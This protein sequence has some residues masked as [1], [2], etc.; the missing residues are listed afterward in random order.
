MALSR[1]ASACA[2][3]KGSRFDADLGVAL[4]FTAHPTCV[5][6]FLN[7][8]SEL[9][10]G[11][12]N[13]SNNARRCFNRTFPSEATICRAPSTARVIILSSVQQLYPARPLSCPKQERGQIKTPRESLEGFCCSNGQIR[14]ERYIPLG[15]RFRCLSSEVFFAGFQTK[16]CFLLPLCSQIRWCRHAV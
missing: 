11:I 14:W 15:L 16:R 2:S 7:G 9:P 10:F 5:A 6:K 13:A 3:R 1:L 4:C 8:S 12:R